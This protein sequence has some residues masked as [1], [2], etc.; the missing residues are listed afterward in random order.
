MIEAGCLVALMDNAD[1]AIKAAGKAITKSNDAD[2]IAHFIFN[3]LNW[4]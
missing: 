3:Q 2:G 1:A 4:D